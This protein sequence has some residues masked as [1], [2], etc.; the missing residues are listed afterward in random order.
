MSI[1]FPYTQ[2]SLPATVD[3]RL[4]CARVSIE[5][6]RKPYPHTSAYT[7]L[8]DRCRFSVGNRAAAADGVCPELWKHN[9]HPEFRHTV[10]LSLAACLA[11]GDWPWWRNAKGQWH[12]VEREAVLGEKRRISFFLDACVGFF[13][14][15]SNL[16]A[17]IHILNSML[18][19][20]FYTEKQIFRSADR[21]NKLFQIGIC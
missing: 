19:L 14:L 10:K 9:L 3:L 12:S 4:V 8:I 13:R 1:P 20:L 16:P 5:T 21:R 18:T 2:E 6:D 15:F 7:P 17:M 11:A